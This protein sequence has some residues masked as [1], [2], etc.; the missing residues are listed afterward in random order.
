[1]WWRTK[2]SSC[3]TGGAS[4]ACQSLQKL[5]QVIAHQF[6][7][8]RLLVG[9]IEIQRARLHAHLARDLAHRDGGEPV[10]REE[11]QGRRPDLRPGDIAVTALFSRH[12][13]T[14]SEHTFNSTVPPDDPRT[15]GQ[16]PRLRLA[17]A[18]DAR[19][20]H[21]PSCRHRAGRLRPGHPGA[22]RAA[23]PRGAGRRFP[24]T[25]APRPDPGRCR[26]RCRRAAATEGQSLE[27]RTA[28]LRRRAAA[29]RAMPL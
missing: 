26:H 25:G 17:R 6:E 28:D 10:P 4:G 19:S 21:L 23:R 2:L 22:R 8:K 9:G 15:S 16:H 11:P 5:R 18:W 7:Q 27:A 12:G 24:R 1:M 14:L 3:A 29:L 13:A 20:I